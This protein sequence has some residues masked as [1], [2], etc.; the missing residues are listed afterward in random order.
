[1]GRVATAGLTATMTLVVVA[2]TAPGTT[3]R[4]EPAGPGTTTPAATVT[5][6]TPTGPTASSVPTPTRRSSDSASPT[7]RPDA[8]FDATAAMSDVRLLAGR[9]G[10]RL[11]TGPGFRRAGRVVERRLSDLGYDVRRESFAVPAGDSWGVPV[12]AGRSFNVVAEPPGFDPSRPHVVLGAHLDTVAVAPGA[13]DNAS[14]VAV[15]LELARLVSE[16][17]HDTRLPAVLIAF[18]AEEPRGSGDDLH[19]FGSQHHV[20]ELPRSR[21]AALRAMVSL[22]R[23]GVGSVVPVCTGP[24]SRPGAQQALLRAAARVGVPTTRCENTA[25]DHWSFEKAGVTVARLGST[26]YAAYHSDRDVPAV[27][28]RAQLDRTGRLTW[29]WLR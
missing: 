4:T 2:C 16:A 9:I 13:E 6:A 22:D 21:R 7:A 3:Q 24:L 10:P 27:V 14:G 8:S 1:M 29:A 5:G 23:V 12:R 18:G 19:H 11:A 26:S 15:L 25:S 20:R 28:D 17:G